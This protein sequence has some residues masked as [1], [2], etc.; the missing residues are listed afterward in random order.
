MRSCVL[1]TPPSDPKHGPIDRF[2]SSHDGC[3]EQK[4]ASVSPT[5]Q[6]TSWM[7]ILRRRGF[8]ARDPPHQ[9]IHHSYSLT[10]SWI[11]QLI[12]IYY[13]WMTAFYYS[14]YLDGNR[15]VRVDLIGSTVA[16]NS[17]EG[18]SLIVLLSSTRSFSDSPASLM[19]ITI[20]SINGSLLSFIDNDLNFLPFLF[21][22]SVWAYWGC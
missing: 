7:G 20:P 13:S 6:L 17:D 14:R 15:R 3:L 18:Y 4:R 11:N 9:W 8:C 21:F 1:L 10:H 19:G 2:Q 5:F 16:S 12:H 22:F